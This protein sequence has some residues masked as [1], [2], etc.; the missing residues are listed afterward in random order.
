MIQKLVRQMLTA[1]IFSALTVSLCLLIDNVMIGQFLGEECIAAYGLA[2]PLLLAVGA[3]ASLLSA[4][5]QVVCSRALGKGDQEGANGGYSSAIAVAGIVSFAAMALVIPFRSFFARI[6]GAGSSGELFEQ[7]RGYLAG[8]SIGAPATMGALILVPFL[9]MAGKSGL[10]IAA[11]L[12]MTV[13]D[14]ALDLL[15]VLVFHGGM[16]GMG[17]ASA[18]SYY[19]ALLVG[20]SYFAAPKSAFR[21]SR[22]AVKKKTVVELFQAG[23][24]AGFNMISSVI[25]MFIMNRLVGGLA[26][27][28]AVAAY[29]VSSSL[30]GAANCVTTGIGGVSLTLSSI[31]YHEEDGSS[32]KKLLAVLWRY[33]AALSLGMG[34]LVIAFAPALVSLFIPAAGKTR[35]MAVLGLRLFTV[36]M[37]PSSL[38]AAVKNAWQACGRTRLME[39]FCLLEGA[40][41]PAL[42]AFVMSR[43]LGTTGAWL[44]FGIGEILASVFIL[45]LVRRKT[46]KTAWQDGAALLPEK[47]FGAPADQQLEMNLRSMQ[48]VSDAA[49]KAEQFCLSHG[50]DAR[51]SN[52]IAL[53]IEEMAGNTI[54]HGFTMDQKEH[55]LSILIMHKP[56]LWILRFRDDCGAFDPLHYVPTE[57]KD[58]LG[59]RLVTG[60]VNDARYTYSMNMNNLVLKL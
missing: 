55:H 1:Q 56:D 59:I 42:A 54:Q 57:G 16:F 45:I 32:L 39:I 53:C 22:R 48:E 36:G 9:Q 11:V 50:Q 46:G 19:V 5:V 38:N 27:S 6:L 30:G 13:A 21:F 25:L 29:A 52:H 47:N 18:I 35:D 40:G 12:G 17:L 3:V 43:F 2:N 60:M 41:F 24:P 8:F 4:G 14:V 10:L 44:G 28:A 23:I 37:I 34:L 26:G 20:G 7:T 31:F 51:I 58:A 15:N 33:G 49:R